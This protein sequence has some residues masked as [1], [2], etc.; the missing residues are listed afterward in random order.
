MQQLGMTD[1]D[2][3]TSYPTL[4]AIDLV[5]ASAFAEDHREE[6]ERDIR[7]NEEA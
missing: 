3:L 6:I 7:E 1:A 4:Q 2:I 5:E